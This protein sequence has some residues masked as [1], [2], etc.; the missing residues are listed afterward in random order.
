MSLLKQSHT[1]LVPV[2]IIYFVLLH[3]TVGRVK[4]NF[5]LSYL[6]YLLWNLQDQLPPTL[7]FF[8]FK[9]PSFCQP[10]RWLSLDL[11]WKPLPELHYVGAGTVLVCDSRTC[12]PQAQLCPSFA[13]PHRHTP[14]HHA[15]SES[16]CH[17]LW[18]QNV[19]FEIKTSY[20]WSW[21]LVKVVGHLAVPGNIRKNEKHFGFHKP[22]IKIWSWQGQSLVKSCCLMAALQWLVCIL[23][24]PWSLVTH[25]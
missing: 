15:H 23:P 1:F 3:K 25:S 12:V 10:P 24:Q 9:H 5:C 14:H 21:P 6:L 2:T 4:S 18:W 13:C 20:W 16:F 11:L 22:G 7:S 19:P 8:Q 17:P